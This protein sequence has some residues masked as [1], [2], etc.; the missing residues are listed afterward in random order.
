VVAI[1]EGYSSCAQGP[2]K[3]RKSTAA[4]NKISRK[5]ETRITARAKGEPSLRMQ[6]IVAYG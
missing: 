5:K 1:T 2:N 6:G 4:K 3:K